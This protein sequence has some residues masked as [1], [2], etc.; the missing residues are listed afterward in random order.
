M[1]R[2]LKRSINPSKGSS[3]GFTLIEL[4]IVMSIMAA[5]LAVAAP[6]M[7]NWVRG[8][9]A[10]DAAFQM[11]MD[12]QRARMLA[13][14]RGVNCSIM[15]D[16]PGPNQYTISIINEV[17][18]LGRYRGTVVFSNA[19]DISDPVITFTPQGVCQIPG[20]FYLSDQN[21]RFRVRATV[22]GAVSVHW[23]SSGQWK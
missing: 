12:L 13:I 8:R 23:D 1:R 21:R 10:R 14:Q 20:M 9:G 19:P 22:A 11:S 7:I 2:L 3:S 4:V 15:I 17:M 16:T 5:L 18:D 6:P